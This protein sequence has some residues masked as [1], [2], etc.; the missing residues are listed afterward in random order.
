MKRNPSAETASATADLMVKLASSIDEGRARQRQLAPDAAADK[1]VRHL[2]KKA[3]QNDLGA[4]VD[5]FSSGLGLARE[6]LHREDEHDSSYWL[7]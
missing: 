4:I 3:A 5:F 6:A 2:S 1:L 7:G